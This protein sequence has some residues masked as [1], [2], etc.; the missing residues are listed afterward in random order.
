MQPWE[1]RKHIETE[2]VRTH[3]MTFEPQSTCAV[4]LF[5]VLPVCIWIRLTG[6]ATADAVKSEALRALFRKSDINN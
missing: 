4:R 1:I 2:R 3:F 6:V 5:L